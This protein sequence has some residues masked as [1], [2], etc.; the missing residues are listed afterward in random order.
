MCLGPQQPVGSLTEEIVKS[1]L[2]GQLVGCRDQEAARSGRACMGRFHD[3]IFAARDDV[4]QG[5]YS[6]HAIRLL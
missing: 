4:K 6:C 5:H 3:G 2:G 1:R